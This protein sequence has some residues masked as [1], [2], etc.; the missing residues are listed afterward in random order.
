MSRDLSGTISTMFRGNTF[1]YAWSD[2]NATDSGLPSKYMEIPISGNTI[3]MPIFAFNTFYHLV[4]EERDGDIDSIVVKLDTTGKIP[5]YKSLD[6]NMKDVL[7]EGYPGTRLVKVKVKDSEDT[8]ITYYATGGAIFDMD[9]NPLM[10]CYYLIRKDNRSTVNSGEPDTA[11][12][13]YKVVKPVLWVDYR[14][15]IAKSDPME[16]FIANKMVN[17]CLE[18]NYNLGPHYMNRR[19]LRAIDRKVRVE[20]D[21]CPFNIFVT[22]TPSIST[23]NQQ[24]IQVAKDHIEE[25]TQ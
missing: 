16:K 24:L 6:R 14:P 9:L 18:G 4:K 21:R 22:D 20:I 12:T 2:R 25:L 15:V 19:F 23:T 17:T 8:E 3:L 11:V 13:T 5:R 7:L 10:I 1:C